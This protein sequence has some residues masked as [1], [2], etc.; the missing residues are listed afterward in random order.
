ML[1]AA[2]QRF[3]DQSLTDGNPI[4]A[5]YIDTLQ[6]YEDNECEVLR[7]LVGI[8]DLSDMQQ[9]VK[10]MESEVIV[11]MLSIQNFKIP[12]TKKEVNPEDVL[13]AD[14]DEL[15]L[16]P[17]DSLVECP[18]PKQLLQTQLPHK[19]EHIKANDPRRRF[20]GTIVEVKR[21]S[22]TFECSKLKGMPLAG[23]YLVIFRSSRI[24]YRLMYDALDQ[25]EHDDATRR[26]LFPRD[27]QWISAR[28]PQPALRLIN[29]TISSN[30]EQLQAVS[31]IVAGPST[32]APYIIFGPPGTGKTT[33]IVEA[34]LQLHLNPK[35]RIL[36]AAGSNS[37]CDTIA[38]KLCAHFE[39]HAVSPLPV[40]R[41]YSKTRLKIVEHTM[42]A[43]LKKYSNCQYQ[44]CQKAKKLK[45]VYKS[46][47]SVI[48][49]INV[50][51]LCSTRVMLL[52]APDTQFTHIFIDE[53]AASTEPEALMS[54]VGLKRKNTHVIL[55]GDHKQLG[56]VIK[57]QRA[58]ELGLGQ[59]LMERLMLRKVY[60]T[61]DFGEYN[62]RLQTRLRRNYRSHPAIVALYN[63]LYYNG[64]LLA[65]AP[66]QQ[67][68]QAAQCSLLRNKQSPII[69]HAVS[70]ETTRETNSTSS[71]NDPE[72]LVVCWYVEQLLK[73]GLSDQISVKQEDIGV[74]SPY[75]A[76]CRLVTRLLRQRGQ[77]QVEVGSVESYQGREK[78]I[79][80][81][82]LV[83]SKGYASGFATNPRRINVF[84][85]R[86]KSLLIIIGNPQSLNSKKDFQYIFKQC[87][88]Q[89][90]LYTEKPNENK[91][92]NELKTSVNENKA[93]FANTNKNVEV[94]KPYNTSNI[95]IDNKIVVNTTRATV[96]SPVR[97]P[98]YFPYLER[99]KDRVE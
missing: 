50:A 3:N 68:N 7:T 8:E 61:N 58:V 9:F 59:S 62:I 41:Y 95:K 63:E 14:I 79:I 89:G 24:T 56:P 23:R 55:S 98:I 13:T 32:L 76:Q 69:F 36:V 46:F 85:S 20:V 16:V 66:L 22:V 27:Y 15:V 74:V 60:D 71:Y 77:A 96:I 21:N 31:Q 70:G 83:C 10:L 97:S 81:A 53:A 30:A 40:V 43:L 91:P 65:K 19:H 73:K 6:L 12:L 88:L 52:Q 78:L 2:A 82:T 11:Q 90:N 33:T 17:R 57:C 64:E 38:V 37:A 47:G 35:N 18:M 72:A 86:P 25:L 54:I 42:P 5:D 84:L 1:K 49:K 39:K 44:Y 75:L 26:Y 80:I 48:T 93:S 87:N 92:K 99:A 29:P 34:I 28:N 67:V 4:F 94:L 45:N 51:T